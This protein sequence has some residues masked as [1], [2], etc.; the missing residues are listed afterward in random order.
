MANIAQR[1]TEL[2]G[3]RARHKIKTTMMGAPTL[4]PYLR[5]MAKLAPSSQATG[6]LYDWQAA[7][8]DAGDL[9]T[10]MAPEER[11][12]AQILT[13]MHKTPAA[14][15]ARPSVRSRKWTTEEFTH[16]LHTIRD[17]GDADWDERIRMFNETYDLP[18]HERARDARTKAA[19]LQK[20]NGDLG[21]WGAQGLLVRV[22][23]KLRELGDEDEV[24][25][26]QI[27]AGDDDRMVVDL[28]DDWRGSGRL[29]KRTA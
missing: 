22:E 5:E 15:R 11:Y 10:Q 24:T 8:R 23:S 7:C 9:P 6:Q 19:V 2:T 28:T 4:N 3:E 27:L 16:L 21:T 12:A 1:L 20:L 18:D 13:E 17:K 14:R 26:G 29:G 25:T